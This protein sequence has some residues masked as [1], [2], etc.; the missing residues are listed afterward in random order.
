MEMLSAARTVVQ[1]VLAANSNNKIVKDWQMAVRLS[2]LAGP[3]AQRIAAV[4]M[5]LLV[6]S[7]S[8]IGDGRL[9]ATEADTQRVQTS[10]EQTRC[11]RSRAE[12]AEAAC[13]ACRRCAE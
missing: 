6:S 9:A 12:L 4:T 2:A 1:P 5:C 8:G 3:C 10:S 11:Y 13:M 7:C